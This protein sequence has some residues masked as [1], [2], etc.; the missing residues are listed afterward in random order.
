MS[1]DETVWHSISYN[2]E[3]PDDKWEPYVFS[4]GPS[5]DGTVLIGRANGDPEVEIDKSFEF[6]FA[7]RA[8]AAITLI[9][10]LVMDVIGE[11]D[12]HQP[13]LYEAY[14]LR[15]AHDPTAAF[16]PE[17]YAGE[18]ARLPTS[19]A[20]FSP[21]AAGQVVTANFSFVVGDA[22]ELEI[23]IRERRGDDFV[24]G[25]LSGRYYTPIDNQRG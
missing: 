21:I 10:A 19:P 6:P 1:S 13:E 14:A 9:D 20:Y 11:W 5:A 15:V 23:L 18:T 22:D 8:H 4:I 3:T 25:V 24:D 12:W 16:D 17:Q 7:S 2:L